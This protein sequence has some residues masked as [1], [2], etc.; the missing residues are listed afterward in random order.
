MLLFSLLHYLASLWI[1]GNCKSFPHSGLQLSGESNAIRFFSNNRKIRP[2]LAWSP[3]HQIVTYI[4]GSSLGNPGQNGIG[5]VRCS[6]C[7][8][9]AF[10]FCPLFWFFSLARNLFWFCQLE[11]L[12]DCNSLIGCR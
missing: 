7:H 4:D 12:V 10:H 8:V 2:P 3:L 6:C 5:S 9:F 11:Q 1:K